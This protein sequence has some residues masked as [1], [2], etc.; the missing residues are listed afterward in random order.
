MTL[1]FP[2]APVRYLVSGW[3]SWSLT[4]WI[5]TDRPLHPMRPSILHPGQTDP[6]HAGERVPNGSWYGAVELSERK[7]VFLGALGLES[8][9]KLDGLI[10]TGLY[11]KGDGDWF[12]ASGDEDEIMSR[13]AELLG[14]RL[15]CG[16]PKPNPR[17]WCSW[18]SLYTEIYEK[19]L[20]KILNDLG[21][22]DDPNA[23]PFDIFQIDDGWQVGI[24]D[25]EAE[26]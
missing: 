12:I 22:K 15:G 2:S 7:I 13:Y 3:Q 5:N 19:Q 18:Y 16:Q 20:L 14:D 23:Y 25:W 4:S 24:G 10:L 21:K 11:E 8:H 26:R 1:N 17:I 6:V 9:V